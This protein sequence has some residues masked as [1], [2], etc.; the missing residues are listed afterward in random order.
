M[1]LHLGC[2]HLR[3]ETLTDVRTKV[4]DNKCNARL[5]NLSLTYTNKKRKNFQYRCLSEAYQREKQKKHRAYQTYSTVRYVRRPELFLRSLMFNIIKEKNPAQTLLLCFHIS[6]TILKILS[7][8]SA[9]KSY[10]F[11]TSALMQN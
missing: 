3:E 8:D 4:L 11:Q 5:Y 9:L 6:K 10:S 7:T 2:K 1:R